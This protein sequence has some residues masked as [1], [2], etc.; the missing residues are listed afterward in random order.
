VSDLRQQI[1]HARI[2]LHRYQLKLEMLKERENELKA[3]IDA[4]RGQLSSTVN[5]TSKEEG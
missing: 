2:Q 5:Q 3:E 4:V 1:N